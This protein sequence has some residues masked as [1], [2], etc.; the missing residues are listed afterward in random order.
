VTGVMEHITAD[1]AWI[2]KRPGAREDYGV[3][4]GSAAQIDAG[5]LAAVY[6]AGT[7]SSSLPADDPG[8]APWV[9]FG[10]HRGLAARPVLSV[11]VSDPWQD[12]DQTGRPIWPRRLFACWYDEV[13]AYRLSY[14]ALWEA[15][16][17]M[18]LPR[19]DSEPVPLA[20]RPEP[21]D[22]VVAAI[23][24]IGLERV[25]AIAAALLDG[26]VVLTGTGNLRL[27]D[28][29]AAADR[30]G[31][32][33][34]V[35]A[36]LPYG[37][38]ADMS[39]SSAIDNTVAHRIRLVLGGYASAGQQAAG[40]HDAPVRPGRGI[41]H[42]Y[43]AMLLERVHWEGL[44]AVIAY[45]RDA[46]TV[47]AFDS[48]EAAL[49]ILDGLNRTWHTIRNANAST[50]SLEAS[51]AFFGGEP[52]ENETLWR[53]ADLDPR[54]RTRLLRPLLDSDDRQAAEILG[55]NWSVLADDVAALVS[56]RL[57]D[58]DA[59]GAARSLAIAESFLA[60]AAADW[61]LH[62]L[63]RPHGPVGQAQSRAVSIRAAL[64]RQLPSVPAPGTLS[65]TRASIWCGPADGWQEML[66][67]ELLSGEL[68]AEA[69]RAVAWVA[70]LTAPAAEGSGRAGATGSHPE[71]PAAQTDPPRWLAALAYTLA[72][73]GDGDR[74]SIRTLVRSDPAWAAIVLRLA[75]RAGRVR[76]VLEVPGLADDLIGVAAAPPTRPGR[77]DG[78][79]ALAEAASGPLWDYGVDPAVIAAIDVARTLLGGQ[80]PSFPS[81]QPGQVARYDEGMARV[82]GL[83]S[84]QGAPSGA[85]LDAVRSSLRKAR[86]VHHL[87][88]TVEQVIASPGVLSR[89]ADERFGA[90]ASVLALAMYRAWRAGM[91]VARIHELMARTSA[92]GATLDQ[93]VGYRELDEVLREFADLLAFP[94]NEA[95]GRSPRPDDLRAQARDVLAESREFVCA[96]GFGTSYG[97]GFRRQ[98]DLQLRD[99][100]IAVRRARRRL[101]RSIRAPSQRG[102]QR[103]GPEPG[104]ND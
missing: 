73:A 65:E 13:A 69:D 100:L 52:S 5:S 104:D 35:A 26:P 82:L 102:R 78:R 49:R 42:D 86:A 7:P 16:A 80:P 84:V 68:D 39:A 95:N 72:D 27:C 88:A 2:S 61:L 43:L 90:P 19:A 44:P 40:L 1:W 71:E 54:A 36:L 76:E 3:L 66:I 20:L 24:G 85:G 46:T 11:A 77:E 17:G 23:G 15:V 63:V 87:Q 8:A 29:A 98:L 57:D 103:S 56:R 30:L 75:T 60:P 59:R 99:E 10:S 55:R 70:W 21:A 18:D 94:P 101:R 93:R 48:P 41:A 14:R 67:R 79:R 38:R 81:N 74:E 32:L 9:T 34:A 45:L 6:V 22:R 91:P 50:E 96:G 47:C 92:P 89:Q 64:L 33:D 53:S 31:A 37:F 58:G 62:L 4:A 97:L 51:C 25:A 12:R 83:P 28:E